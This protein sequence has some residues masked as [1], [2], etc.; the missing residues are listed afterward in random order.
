[1]YNCLAVDVWDQ[2]QVKRQFIER[3]VSEKFDEIFIFTQNEWE[4]F[5]LFDELVPSLLN[6]FLEHSGTNI[7]VITSLVNPLP[8]DPGH[9]GYNLKFWSTYWL[10]KTYGILKRPHL[11]DERQE[12]RSKASGLKHHNIMM[13]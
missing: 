2:R 10:Y 3:L 8:N 7:N 5:S 4:Y 9:K 12:Q 11:I 6:Y 1:M 13:F